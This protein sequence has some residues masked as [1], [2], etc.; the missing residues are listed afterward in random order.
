[1]STALA[2]WC[3]KRGIDSSASDRSMSDVPLDPPPLG[4]LRRK[5]AIDAGFDLEPERDGGWW[6]LR[7]SGELGVAWV[8][9]EEVADGALLALPLASHLAELKLP[10]APPLANGGLRRPW[11]PPGAAGQVFCSSPQVLYKTLRRL[12]V[13]RLDAPPRL[14][15]RMEI[16]VAEALAVTG[17]PQGIAPSTEV[18][19]QVRR[20]IGQG[21][22]R[23]ALI[24]FWE[25]RCAVTGL[26]VPELLRASHAKPW[27]VASDIERLSVYNGVLL[28]AHFDVL[29]DQGFLTFDDAGRGVP[30][31]RLSAEDWHALAIDPD[32][33]KIRSVHPDHLPYLAYHRAYVFVG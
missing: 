32:T 6:R 30:S 14:L 13:L 12:Y 21:L 19:A 1:V 10:P 28:A 8:Y 24:D 23:E 29:F 33:I 5:A 17:I 26:A 18:V 15:K 16:E 22:F 20:R 7:A 31:R 4:S 2:A 9:P 3:L 11:L 25:G 27:A